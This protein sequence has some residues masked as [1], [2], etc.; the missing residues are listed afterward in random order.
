MKNLI[1]KE[2]PDYIEGYGEVKHYRGP[3]AKL[4]EGLKRQAPIV[5]TVRPGE[6]KLLSS[7]EEAFLKI[8]IT[9]GMTLSFHHHLRNGDNVIN[10]VIDTAA[11]LGIK[12][13]K[14]A[15]SGIFP[16]HE[17]L[18]GHIENGVV[19]GFDLNGM[20]G[21]VAKYI[22]QGNMKN[23]VTLRTH[24]GRA[25]AI[26]CGQMHIDVAFIGAPAADR[27]GNVTGT[28]GPAACGSLGYALM[29]AEYADYV[30]AVTD[31]LEE[32]PLA[33][34]SIPQTR[35]DY[36]VKVGSIGD[37][38]GIMSGTI[39]I[40][41]N[42]LQ[43]KIAEMAAEA[44]YAAGIIKEGFSMQ[45]GAGGVPLAVSD[46]VRKIMEKDKVAGSFILGGITGYF[47]D[48]LEKGLFKTA[49]DVQ[50]FDFEAIRSLNENPNHIEISAGF[51]ANPYNSG[52]LVN[53]LDVVVLGATE[54]D[55]DFNVN[56]ATGADGMV[57]A[58]IGGHGDTAAG[59]KTA[60]VVANL[61][62]GRLPLVMDRVSTVTTPGETIDMLV[63]ERGIAVNPKRPE[64]KEKLLAAGLPV[65]DIAELK[66]T[67]ED[68]AGV[69]E[70]LVTED[71]IVAVVEYRDG[72]VIDVV[73]QAKP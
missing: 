13:L 67:A 2:I 4:P 72:T 62:R 44:I 56:V 71:K 20:L 41:K 8:P 28:K 33:P 54:I 21:P 57:M 23:P 55:L 12:D 58:G 26:E 1:G 61:L 11:R 69:P 24:G 65:K 5:K 15:S 17:P 52:C 48:M 43:L 60:I 66:K 18:I 38:N 7:L 64:L 14:I 3:F 59:A 25:R 36:V 50:S 73:R 10:M 27:Y 51:Y 40:T 19:A 53:K 39:R 42:P 63:T 45:T 6:E 30:V 32:F 68:I 9:D 70:R 49:F 37:P 31:C 34:A 16:V 22:S 29:D 47:V 35:V 46:Y